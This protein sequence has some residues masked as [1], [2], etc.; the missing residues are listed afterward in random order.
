M[1]ADAVAALDGG[2]D[3]LAPIRALVAQAPGRLRPGGWLLLEIG[4]GTAEM[5]I[6][7][8]GQELATTWKP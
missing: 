8:M 3:G 6:I 1:E 7:T 2:P 5:Q 4:A